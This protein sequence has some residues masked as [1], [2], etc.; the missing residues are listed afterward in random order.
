MAR[1]T[2][3][4]RKELDAR[5]DE[6]AARVSRAIRTTLRDVAQTTR[7][8]DD[9]AR[10]QT[11][12]RSVVANAL[13]PRLRAAWDDAVAGVRVQ[14]E[15]INT[16]EQ[17]TLVAAVFDIPKVANPLAEA[18][19]A[20]ATNR[21]VAIG[22]VVWYTA[23]GEMLTGLQLGEG[24]A[25]LKERVIASANVSQKRAEVIARTE[26]N[27]AMNN[28]AYQQMK[29]LDVATIKEWIATDDTRTRESHAEVDGEEIDGD[30]KFMVGG[31]PMDHPHDLNAPP[32]ET[33]NCR[34]TLAWE[35]IDDDDDDDDE[36]AALTAGVAFHL[37]GEHNQDSH[38]RD[39]PDKLK[40]SGE[41]TKSGSAFKVGK[42]LKITNAF[43]YKSHPIGTT[44]AITDDGRTKVVYTGATGKLFNAVLG[45]Y[46]T[47][48]RLSTDHEWQ[49]G[50]KFSKG[51]MY[52]WFKEM[53]SDGYNWHEPAADN[54]SDDSDAA[55]AVQSA[56]KDTTASNQA[57][58]VGKKLKITHGLVHKKHEPGTIIAV[59]G[60]DDKRVIWDGF[61]YRLQQKLGHGGWT[62]DKSVKKSKA[63]V[64][65]NAYDSDWREP[66]DDSGSNTSPA[67]AP[68][69]KPSAQSAA[70]PGATSPDTP[71]SSVTTPSD[72][73]GSSSTTGYAK[74]GK[75][76]QFKDS[77]GDEWLVESYSNTNAAKSNVLASQLYSTLG[78]KTPQVDLVTLDEV[79]FPKAV[80]KVGT[81]KFAVSGESDPNAVYSKVVANS[82]L[83]NQLYDGFAI[84]LW[85][86]NT[87]TAAFENLTVDSDNN[88]IRDIKDILDS[89][90]TLTDKI[91]QD[92]IDKMTSASQGNSGSVLNP[93]PK[94]AAYVGIPDD[95]IVEGVRK[96]AGLSPK[97]IDELVDSMGFGPLTADKYKKK[98]KSRRQS[99]IDII[100][101]QW[102]EPVSGG[103]I[104]P[105]PVTPVGPHKSS[106]ALTPPL[107]PTPAP[108]TTS[109]SS[110]ASEYP[111][112]DP[113]FT[114]KS[115]YKKGGVFEN[116]YGDA[117]K[118]T[119]AQSVSHARNELLASRLYAYA[120]IG[121]DHNDIV[122]TDPSKLNSP[123]GV[124]VL[125]TYRPGEVSLIDAMKTTPVVQKQVNENFAFDAW[126]G[127]WDVVGLGYENLT[128]GKDGA[129]RRAN[130]G[131][132][133]LYRANGEPK[134][135]AFGDTVNEI[136]S[137]RDP[138]QNPSAAKIFANVTDDDIRAG[139]ARIEK[140]TPDDIDYLV[141][142]SGFTGKE[143]D[144]LSSKLQARRADLISKYGSNAPKP[145]QSSGPAAST[146]PTATNALGGTTKTYTALQKA[147]VQAIFNKHN[148]KWHNKTDQIYD[149]A[150]E[151]ST[152]HSDLT[153]ADALDIM[154]QSLKKKTGNPFR[155]KV[156]KWL[157]TKAGKSHAL[158]KGSSAALGGTAP[159]TPPATVPAPSVTTPSVAT[160]SGGGGGGYYQNLNRPSATFMQEQMN[161]ATPPPWTNAQHNALRT[162]TGSAYSTINKCARGVTPCDQTTKD[163]LDNI[164]SA[165]K[166]S[167]SNVILYRATNLHTFGL[168]TTSELESLIGKTISDNGVISTSITKIGWQGH[169]RLEI[170]APK[171]SHMAWVQPISLHPTENEMVLAPGTH[172]EVLSVNKVYTNGVH[173][174]DVKLRVIPGSDT[175]SRELKQQ[176][177]LTPA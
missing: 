83:R 171:G 58:G 162:Y 69:A 22:D 116:K 148:L 110:E 173:Y 34:C 9:L 48:N 151:V 51:G 167:T 57:S 93:Q 79:N 42:K 26:V 140:I 99:L 82:H 153:I 135:A 40:N 17:A 86:N 36:S 117:Y 81:R 37:K 176:K 24:V 13:A 131:G 113:T 163:L 104:S 77:N 106:V 105:Q 30:A 25:E 133:L 129:V 50:S 54:D 127:N 139:V 130:L 32:G 177:E 87:Q 164:K 78:I 23:R 55:S 134:G 39:K 16:R 43:V 137:L 53:E 61:E 11:V 124:G 14:L 4:S 20:D 150:H 119:P 68:T 45:P 122:Q 71:A 46:T 118:I 158:S 144:L 88:L 156:E 29:A 8:V 64:E 102:G 101:N 96:I 38:G 126:L 62:T 136:D 75:A 98:L 121:V 128:V 143:A 2:G 120:A 74:T 6:F 10:I 49:V 5:G 152:T 154:D 80:K 155:T 174:T 166:P 28:G 33:I 85:L 100:E 60:S 132:S 125:T 59:N 19:L 145:A 141:S 27:S 170:E 165:M 31:F 109:V 114:K 172:Y 138:K 159:T 91:T 142:K 103:E 21:L 52:K 3:P 66:S 123:S 7:D 146:L 111:Q 112:M 107:T 56:Q 95:K 1:V 41:S 115:P 15:K 147:K 97:Q 63:Y 44:V 35:I 108:A 169:V 157:K 70:K 67:S 94:P 47:Y 149:A 76:G 84:D 161:K 18:F 73:S 12:W 92:D 72:A 175:R 168:A 90:S 160:P 65:I 89:G